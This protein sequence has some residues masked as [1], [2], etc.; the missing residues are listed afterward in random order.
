MFGHSFWRVCGH[1][2]NEKVQSSCGLS[3]EIIETCATQQ[4]SADANVSQGMQYFCVKYIV[5]K[6]AD[7]LATLSKSH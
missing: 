2:R 7:C 1:A 6:H 4:D 3:I 5:Y